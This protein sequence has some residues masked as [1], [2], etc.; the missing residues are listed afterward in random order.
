MKTLKY[1]FLILT[2]SFLALSCGF[3]A[4]SSSLTFTLPLDL[5]K[6][7]AESSTSDESSSSEDITY[8][9]RI[10]VWG[11]FENSPISQEWDFSSSD[12]KNATKKQYKMEK[13]PVNEKVEVC[14]FLFKNENGDKSL[15]YMSHDG[16]NK[17][18]TIFLCQEEHEITL[19]LYKLTDSK[20]DS[21]ESGSGSDTGAEDSSEESEKL[22]KNFVKV[23]G[24]TVTGATNT[25]NYA[26]VFIENR[27]VTLSDFY[28]AKYEVT[29]EEYSTVMSS[30]SVT[31]TDSEGKQA[32]YTL[33]ASPSLCTSS[34]T[35]YALKNQTDTK[36][37]VE[38]VTW[39]DAIYFCNA[40]SQS[41]GLT[42]AYKIVVTE[43]SSHSSDT[44]TTGGTS[45][46]TYHIKAA[47]VELVENANGY[48]LPT[49]A[50]W[51]FAGRGGD[52][53]GDDTQWTFSFSGA[54]CAK[55][56]NE[57]STYSKL[58]NSGLDNFG[59][60][61]YNNK[62]GTSTSGKQLEDANY[63][64]IEEACGTH[65]VGKLG[66]NSLGLYDMS[67]NVAEWCYDWYEDVT[68]TAVSN[69]TGPA[70][71]TKKVRRG[72]SWY[73][74]ANQCTVCYRGLQVLPTEKD[75][76]TGFR[77][78]RSIPSA[79]SGDESSAS[80]A[81]GASSGDEST[82]GAAGTSE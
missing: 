81:D 47:T 44:S 66:A 64:A 62:T 34:S 75:A 32:E 65:E 14:A 26:G 56:G 27:T 50:E 74:A 58:Y 41:D 25:Y 3:K 15:I 60:Y 28:I 2:L 8:T 37:P 13:L 40:K 63:N 73:H 42:P 17:A 52:P 71:G 45:S 24:Q 59:W 36:R 48:R 11:N 22:L 67:G 7:E 70:P 79:S 31:V 21:G 57:T 18:D 10:S 23:N 51:E 49:E 80:S 53:T 33:E 38:N 61:A 16:N 12:L 1:F 30:K 77:L 55:D 43:V 20:S 54:N 46:S 76:Y 69:P 39:Y 78:V 6:D 82:S 35:T 19:T 9:L 5:L 72:G 4:P 68:A 29:Q